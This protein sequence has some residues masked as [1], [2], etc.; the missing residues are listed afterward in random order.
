M[1]VDVETLKQNHLW[2][3]SGLA[4]ILGKGIVFVMHDTQRIVRNI[5][6]QSTSMFLEIMFLA[7][8]DVV[9]HDFNVFVSV[10]T[11]LDMVQTKGMDK[12][13]LNSAISREVKLHGWKCS[14]NWTNT[15]LNDIR[16]QDSSPELPSST[17]LRRNNILYS[18]LLLWHSCQYQQQSFPYSRLE[19]LAKT[20]AKSFMNH[21]V[22]K[23]ENNA[24]DQSLVQS[25]K[26]TGNFASDICRH[27]TV[28][29]VWNDTSSPSV[30]GFRKGLAHFFISSKVGFVLVFSQAQIVNDLDSIF[31]NQRFIIVVLNGGIQTSEGFHWNEG[32]ILTHSRSCWFLT[33]SWSCGWNSHSWSK[34]Q[35]N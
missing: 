25:I 20:I 17:F 30:F 12:F 4:V 15:Y 16:C 34:H 28:E 10:L 31:V 8:F 5:K 29:F 9:P 33:H 24:I 19:N 6:G 1:I 27:S 3:D 14:W 32:T 13:M 7:W 11:T 35:T 26:S 21:Y 18:L 2:N 23:P 22:N